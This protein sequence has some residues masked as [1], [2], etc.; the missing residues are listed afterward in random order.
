MKAVN[1]TIPTAEPVS[2]DRAAPSPLLNANKNPEPTRNGK[3]R[4]RP[5]AR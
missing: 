3:V 5:P 2:V 1:A 4:T